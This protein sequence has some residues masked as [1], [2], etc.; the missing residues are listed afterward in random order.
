MQPHKGQKWLSRDPQLP[1]GLPLKPPLGED[2]EGRLEALECPTGKWMVPTGT[3][4]ET[5]R[6]HMS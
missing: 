1:A 5:T 4:K 3:V 6:D 2:P